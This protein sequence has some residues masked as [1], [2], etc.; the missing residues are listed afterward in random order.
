MMIGQMIEAWHERGYVSVDLGLDDDWI[1][2]VRDDVLNAPA[3]FRSQKEY[4]QDE[5]PR[6]FQAWKYSEVVRKLAV[7]P[8]V[9]RTIKELTGKDAKPFQTLNF[10]M[11][12]QQPL[13]QDAIHFDCDPPGHMVGCWVAL[14]D[15][16]AD[17][18]PLIVCPGSH[19]EPRWDFGDLGWATPVR[20]EEQPAYRAYEGFLA[21]LAR[22]YGAEYGTIPKG[23][24]LIWHGN[25]IHGGSKIQRPGA[26]RWSQATHYVLDGY[27]RFYCPMFGTDKV[28]PEI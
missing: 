9:L 19:K 18:G 6:I 28:V 22:R 5:N 20:G 13:H 7:H 4:E 8:T 10:R 1:G 17:C 16:T 26:T 23:H 2:T 21:K 15:I 12:S 25:L 24:A 3:E 27:T 14:E 11:G